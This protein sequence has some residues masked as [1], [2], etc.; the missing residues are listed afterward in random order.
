MSKTWRKNPKLAEQEV[1][2]KSS[3]S[4]LII[5]KTQGFLVVHHIFIKRTESHKQGKLNTHLRIVYLLPCYVY[6]YLSIFIIPS[7]LFCTNLILLHSFV[8]SLPSAFLITLEG[9]V[10]V[11]LIN[12]KLIILSSFE[13]L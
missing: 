11:D 13:V 10:S 12:S 4:F 3:L 6:L 7:S 1:F 2:Y 8:Y 9:I 5:G